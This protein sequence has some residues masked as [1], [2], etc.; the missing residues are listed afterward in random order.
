MPMSIFNNYVLS[1]FVAYSVTRPVSCSSFVFHIMTFFA[2]IDIFCLW[3]LILLLAV[4]T[5][6]FWLCLSCWLC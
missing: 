2:Q 3:L 1:A 6:S 4:I 5:A